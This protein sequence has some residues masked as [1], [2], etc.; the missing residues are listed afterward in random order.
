MGS[1]AETHWLTFATAI[2]CY[3]LRSTKPQLLDAAMNHGPGWLRRALHQAGEAP[4]PA[5]RPKEFVPGR[6]ALAHL[7]AGAEE[8]LRKQP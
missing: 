4:Q 6:G 7:T 2:H 1:H 3:K 5:R 8:A